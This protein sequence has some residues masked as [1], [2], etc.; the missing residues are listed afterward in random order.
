MILI[1]IIVG[2]LLGA[3][4][5]FLK[6]KFNIHEVVSTIM[7]NYIISYLTGFFINS[8]FVDPISRASKTVSAASRLTM[9]KVL[10]GGFYCNVPLGHHYCHRYG[11][12]GALYLRKDGLRI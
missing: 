7:I 8:K 2:G 9:T 1:G 6:Y 11:L 10:I 4:V 5:G 3:F 12:R